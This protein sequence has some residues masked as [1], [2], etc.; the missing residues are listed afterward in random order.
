[1]SM[2]CSILR[3]ASCV[4]F[5]LV[6]LAGSSSAAEW[7]QWRGPNRNGT[8]SETIASWPPAK[9]W[10]QPVGEGCS[11]ISVSGGRAYTIGFIDGKDTVYC[12]DAASGEPQWSYSYASGSS[13][14]GAQST[15]TVDGGRV[16]TLGLQGQLHCFEADSGDVVWS[17][18]AKTDTG[19]GDIGWGF[20]SSPLIHGNLVIV[21]VGDHGAAFNKDTGA[22]V[23]GEAG[24]AGHGS[25]VF[26]SPDVLAFYA[27]SRMVGVNAD[28]GALVWWYDRKETANIPDAVVLGDK[29]VVSGCYSNESV[30][31]Q[32]STGQVASTVWKGKWQNCFNTF[33][34][35][36]GYLYG[37]DRRGTM[38][39]QSFADGSEAW[40]QRGYGGESPSVILAGGELLA[41]STSGDL[42]RVQAS[43][44]GYTELG[45]ADDVVSGATW[46]APALANGKLYVRSRPGTL[47]C[48]DVSPGT[49]VAVHTFTATPGT[50]DRGESSTLR[51]RTV[52]AT[53]LSIDEGIGEIG[54]DGSTTVSPVRDTT[55]TIKAEGPGGPVTREITVSIVVPPPSEGLGTGILRE[56]WEGIDGSG[57]LDLTSNAA[58]PNKPSSSAVIASFEGPT[59]TAEAYGARYRGYLIP[60]YTGVY[61]FWIASDDASSLLL[62]TSAEAGAA[63]KIAGVAGWTSPREW[64]KEAGQQSGEIVLSA[65]QMYY[66][67]ALHKEG[68][69]GDNLAVRWQMP[70]GTIE[71]PI[72]GHRLFPFAELEPAAPG[73]DD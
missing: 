56:V 71:E 61:T 45:R 4:G 23:W 62:S 24:L 26:F 21:N 38:R 68:G 67:E 42:V 73:D 13:G 64:S 39:C 60:P 27:G 12:F 41:F 14:Y 32:P 10:S 28:T 48:F 35:A 3:R 9:V 5:V 54:P 25:P 49:D 51:W 1:M 44:S 36:D 46:A 17:K 70:G 20:A 16:Y 65:G 57:L 15:P 40:S 29:V 37:H 8:T 11:S 52:N 19:G 63:V 7:A 33:V 2:C 31:I 59:D 22:Y 6:L 66:I 47:V 18:N 53:A 50:I 34:F 72:P 55:Y 69:G 30:Q 43:P 58:Y